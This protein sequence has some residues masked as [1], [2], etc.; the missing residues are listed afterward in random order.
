[1]YLID[2]AVEPMEP[3]EIF[4]IPG[5]FTT[6]RIDQ[7]TILKGMYAYDLQAE[8]GNWPDRITLRATADYFG[9]V[10]TA[11]PVPLPGSGIQEVGPGDFIQNTGEERMTAVEFEEKYLS[12]VR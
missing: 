11:S 5:L 8:D 2:A 12:H 10:L 9:T 7:S 3:V 1:M 4:G 6:K